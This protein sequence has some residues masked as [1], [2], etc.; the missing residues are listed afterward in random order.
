MVTFYFCE[1]NQIYKHIWKLVMKKT[2]CLFYTQLPQ[3]TSAC[4]VLHCYHGLA[5]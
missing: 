3:S 4:T 1:M 2:S 5:I